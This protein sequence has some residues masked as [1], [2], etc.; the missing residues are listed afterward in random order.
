M[1]NKKNGFL[2]YRRMKQSQFDPGQVMRGSF[3]ESASALRTLRTNAILKDD[4]TH[5]VQELNADNKPTKVTYYQAVRPRRDKI[6]FRGDV[7]GSPSTT[8][9]GKYFTIQEPIT[10][11]TWV[12]YYVVSGTGVAPGIG[13]VEIP[14]SIQSGDFASVVAFATKNELK[15]LNEFQIVTDDI[16]VANIEFEYAE[17]GGENQTVDVAN[18]GFFYTNVI[19]GDSIVV[20][21]VE[22]SYQGT[23]PIYNGNLLTGLNYNPYTASFDVELGE[24]QLESTPNKFNV[25]E[26]PYA[27]AGVEQQIVLPE[28]TKRFKIQVREPNTKMM[29]SDVTNG[30]Q[31]TVRYGC[32]HESPVMNSEGVTLNVT[33]DKSNRIIE[34]LTWR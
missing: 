3:S 18:S 32:H 13:D 14:I 28:G 25:L 19:E 5:F 31:W 4:Y 20:G 34:L 29:I 8:L 6:T 15:Q 27:T 22:L 24:I 2:D 23:S 11:K 30:D 21:E 7:P 16:L 12:F 1:S 26:V 9:A 10:R 17:F 33:L